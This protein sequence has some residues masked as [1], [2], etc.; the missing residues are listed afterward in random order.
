MNK[1]AKIRPLSQA[2]NSTPSVSCPPV[3]N[4][5]RRP[6]CFVSDVKISNRAN[7]AKNASTKIYDQLEKKEKNILKIK[8]WNNS[9]SQLLSLVCF[10]TYLRQARKIR[11]KAGFRGNFLSIYSKISASK[12]DSKVRIF[13][14]FDAVS[15]TYKGFMW[16][17]NLIKYE[18]A[19][20]KY[21]HQKLNGFNDLNLS[22]YFENFFLY[23]WYLF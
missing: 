3:T 14:S 22:K 16:L 11:I 23:F 15:K 4:H 1:F 21:W 5:L 6:K 8:M 12:Q 9:R 10:Q 2:G 17:N 19:N 20:K 7:W 13:S 18:R